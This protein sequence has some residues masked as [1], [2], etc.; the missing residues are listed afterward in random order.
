MSAEVIRPGCSTWFVM[1][2]SGSGAYF[3]WSSSTSHGVYA[4]GSAASPCEHGQ[5]RATHAAPSPPPLGSGRS[6]R[7]GRRPC[8]GG[9]E[10]V[11]PDQIGLAEV[12]HI[13]TYGDD[14]FIV[15]G[16]SMATTGR[17]DH[18]TGRLPSRHVN[19]IN[20]KAPTPPAPPK[21]PT[22][23][24]TPAALRSG[25]SRRRDRHR[26]RGSTGSSCSCGR[27]AETS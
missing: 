17:H 26:A 3:S 14:V 8:A 22:P 11:G 18:V 21:P 5:S 23:P 19:M 12:A 20:R 10:P 13:A 16:S 25:R 9:R 2:P 24:R 7:R 6:R 4:M 1:T 27:S 15:G